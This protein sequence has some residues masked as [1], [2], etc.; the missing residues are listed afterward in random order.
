MVF[1]AWLTL[2]VILMILGM[3]IF[4]RIA[5][6]V[7]LI[8]G[9]TILLLFQ[10]ITPK[11]ALAGMA[12]QGMITVGVLYVVVAGV[13]ET[14]G[15][16]WIVDRLL[17]RPHSVVNA[18]MR[19]MPPVIALSSFL[20]NTPVV[21]MMIPAV[22]EW[23]K[24]FRLPVS[25]LLIPLSYASIFGGVCTLIGTS[26]NLVVYG[27]LIDNHQRT[28]GMFDITWVG[29]PAGLIAFGYI[30]LFGRKLLPNREPVI[31]DADDARQYTV[32]MIVESNCP[33]AGKTIEEARLRNLPG[34][35]LMEIDRNGDIIP[36]VSPQERL[37]VGDRLIFCGIVESVVDLQKI[38]GL[39]PAT[40]QVFKLDAP[41]ANRCLIEAVVSDSCAIIGKSIR[42]GRFRTRYNAVAIAVARNG[43]RIN[44]KIGDIVLQPGDNLLLETHPSF[45]DQQRNS[46]DF[47]LIG[48][49]EGSTPIRHERAL[50]AMI[51]L[52]GMVACAALG[53]LS[54]LKA[55]M[56]AA[57]LML[58]TGC[59]SVN[60]ARRSVDWQ[61]LLVIAASFGLGNALEITGLAKAIAGNLIALGGGNPWISLAIVYF[62]TTAFTELI[63]NN[64]AAVLVFPIA[65]Q[66][67]L[68]LGVS[69]MPFAVTIMLAASASFATPIGYQTNLMVYGP[70]GYRFS[71]YIKIGLPLNILYG[72]ATVI[73]APLVWGF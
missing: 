52:I 15:L 51:I 55:A 56:L 37:H 53:V 58:M 26:T 17:G 20:N 22:K 19:L 23:A 25:Q 18:Q 13:I 60:A 1:G 38:K 21:A 49:V 27:L 35:Y 68:G 39:K 73:L 5:P 11:D 34:M 40:D 4:T 71:D 24:Q 66:T 2:A 70:G 31:G 44:M 61:V 69:V 64:A 16:A 3:L 32:E 59:C 30:L 14:G 72:I 67:A 65:F 57:G 47:Y 45:F 50:V 36:A 48:K 10:V 29:L 33:L 41:R 12:N 42:D 28:L 8:G 7:L 54:M 43:K 63:T 62:V 9:V 6:D 46:R